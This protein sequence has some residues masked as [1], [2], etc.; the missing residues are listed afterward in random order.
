[1]TFGNRR[2]V[3]MYSAARVTKPPK[4]AK[5]LPLENGDHLTAEEFHRRYEAMPELKKAEL[6]NGV[7]YLP[8]PFAAI[9]D[10][11]IPPLENGDLLTV[12]EFERRYENMPEL[13]KAELINGVVYMGSP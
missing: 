3:M 12:E 2:T 6:I 11:G 1:M 7:V 9:K 8:S 10:P 13:K 4:K 5:I